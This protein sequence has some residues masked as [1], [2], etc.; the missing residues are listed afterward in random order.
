MNQIGMKR[1]DKTTISSTTSDLERA[2]LGERL[3]GVVDEQQSNDVLLVGLWK[4][5]KT[6]GEIL[7]LT[8]TIASLRGMKRCKTPLQT[9]K[10]N[11]CHFEM[12]EEEYLSSSNKILDEHFMNGRNL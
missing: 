7:P 6:R 9:I 2:S 11:E 8:E 10:E 12:Q 3:N 4:H 5:L 1:M